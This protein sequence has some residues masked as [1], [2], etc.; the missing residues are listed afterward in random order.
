M[1]HPIPVFL[2]LSGGP[3][4]QGHLKGPQEIG[5]AVGVTMEKGDNS[6]VKM[7]VPMHQ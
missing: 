2:C 5:G 4:L 3:C 1:K 7:T 6:G